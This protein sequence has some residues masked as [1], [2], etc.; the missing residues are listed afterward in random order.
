MYL[1]MILPSL[2]DTQLAH[3]SMNRRLGVVFLP[4]LHNLY[5]ELKGLK[6]ITNT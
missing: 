2:I 1:K 6:S 4:Y 3:G 5:S